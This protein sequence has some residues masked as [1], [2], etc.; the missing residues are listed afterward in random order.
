MHSFFSRELP[1][2][3]KNPSPSHNENPKYTILRSFVFPRQEWGSFGYVHRMTK[4]FVDGTGTG[5]ERAKA[6]GKESGEDRCWELYL[7]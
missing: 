7:S 6:S 2:L 4:G 5:T 3:A 1:K